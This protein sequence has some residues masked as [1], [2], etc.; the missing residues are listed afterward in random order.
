MSPTVANNNFAN[1]DMAIVQSLA[2]QLQITLPKNGD[3]R[4]KAFI[5]HAKEQ[6]IT[7][8][9]DTLNTS[10]DVELNFKR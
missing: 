7:K 2:K 6:M 4:S 5:C 3:L 1:V 8:L 10:N 9:Y